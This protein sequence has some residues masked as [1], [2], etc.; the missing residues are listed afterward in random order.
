MLQVVVNGSQK[1]SSSVRPSQARARVKYSIRYISS[2]SVPARFPVMSR[3][4]LNASAHALSPPRHNDGSGV[5][6]EPHRSRRHRPNAARLGTGW[7][8][9]A[10]ETQLQ[11]VY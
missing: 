4:V 9:K 10:A 3:I 1:N 7:R 5:G 2:S 11:V 6:T 8:D